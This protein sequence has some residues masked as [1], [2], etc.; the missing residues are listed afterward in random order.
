MLDIKRTPAQLPTRGHPLTAGR[1]API[2]DSALPSGCFLDGYHPEALCEPYSGAHFG[3]AD[4]G[5]LGD[6]C[7]RQRTFPGRLSFNSDDCKYGQRIRIQAFSH[8]GRDDCCGGKKSTAH[9]RRMVG[10][11]F[12]KWSPI[13]NSSQSA[14]H[15]ASEISRSFSA[16]PYC[17]PQ[18]TLKAPGKP[19]QPPVCTLRQPGRA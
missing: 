14:L 5:A 1:D 6:A 12:C 3:S 7:H 10:L 8:F 2:D 13:M 19:T 17:P 18:T 15:S 4:V 16:R 9:T 11:L